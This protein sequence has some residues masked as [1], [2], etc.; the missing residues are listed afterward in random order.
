ME[1]LL[2]VINLNFI[3]YSIIFDDLMGQLY[4]FFILMVAA[5]ESALGLALVVIYFRL[6]GGIAISL[7]TLLKS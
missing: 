7:L 5:A 6:R 2:L 1:L 4:G 3:C